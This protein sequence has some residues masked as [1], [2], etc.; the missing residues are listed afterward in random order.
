MHVRTVNTYAW[1]T[2]TRTSKAV[3]PTIAATGNIAIGT[4]KIISELINITAKPPN[5]FNNVWPASILANNLTERLTGLMQYEINSI[6]KRSGWSIRGVPEGKNNDKK[7]NPCLKIPITVTAIKII[8]AIKKV[9][10]IWLV[11]V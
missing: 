11:N 5:T 9:T 7:P 8:I 4:K 2:A 10:I 3:I 6:I 1:S